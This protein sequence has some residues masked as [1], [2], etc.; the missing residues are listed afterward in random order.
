MIL[1]DSSLDVMPYVRIADVVGSPD[2]WNPALANTDTPFPYID[3]SSV[4][5]LTKRICNVASIIPSEAPSRARQLVKSGDV[6]VSTVRPNLNAVAI[7][8]ND[9]DGATASTGFAVL[10]PNLARVNPRYLFHWVQTPEFVRHL[11]SR[12]SGASY[13]AV[14]ET[15][16]KESTLPLPSITEQER[17]VTI[18]DKGTDVLRRTRETLHWVDELLRSAFLA[19]FGE[20]VQHPNVENLP[21]DWRIVPL[22]S[23][24]ATA[25]GCAG[26]P[27]GSSLTRADYV[28]MGGVPVIRGKNLLTERSVFRDEGFA[29]VTAEKAETLKRNIALPGDIIFTQ[30]GTL[31]Q[32]ARIPFTSRY[33]RYVISQSQMKVTLNEELVDPEYLVQ[34]FASPRAGIDLE[35]RTLATGVPHIN[36][37]ILKA[38]PVVLPPL[39]LQ[40]RFAEL[41]S[42]H[43]I[44][45]ER[46][47][48]GASQ[49]E[50][51]AESLAQRAF[52]V[53]KGK[54]IPLGK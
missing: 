32:V 35:L 47:E 23:I 14:T 36:L 9:L 46:V 29:F 8:P 31:G 1:N 28:P 25:N 22:E 12:A 42:R 15:V 6:L 49:A 38:F 41:A 48:R 2:T 24:A 44:V 51:L 27:F 11:T 4:D 54:S 34:Y 19:S 18:L 43:A 37:S 50:R 26:G 45:R 30:R 10:R 13:P 7:V 21:P 52:K 3:I 16:L 40:R 33:P 17:A 53:E 5:S 20:A 39:S